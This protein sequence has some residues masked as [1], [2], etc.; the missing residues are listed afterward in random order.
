MI[1]LIM[2][3]VLA[4]TGDELWDSSYTDQEKCQAEADYMAR[5]YRPGDGAIH[6]G[7]TIGKFEGVG[8]GF[9]DLPSTC[10]PDPSLGYRVT[11]DATAKR[12][13]M[14]FRVRSWR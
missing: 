3:L 8:R 11:G 4:R 2:C 13:G 7:R 12:G 6:Y 14:T 9:C 5:V 10:T 1:S